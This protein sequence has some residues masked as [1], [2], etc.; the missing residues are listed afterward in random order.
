MCVCVCVCVCVYV[1]VWCAYVCA[2]GVCMYVC[3]VCMCVC[4]PTFACIHM[5]YMCVLQLTFEILSIFP[6]L[7]EL[8]RDAIVYY[9]DLAIGL[10]PS[11]NED[12]AVTELREILWLAWYLIK[13]TKS[14]CV[15]WGGGS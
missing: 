2:W 14:K 13:I 4:M 7:L 1:C 8:Y 3:V 15:V 10:D 5:C 11:P 9:M 6:P 12:E